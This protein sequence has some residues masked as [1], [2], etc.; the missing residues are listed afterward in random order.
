MAPRSVHWPALRDEYVTGDDH[1]TH[2]T[3]ATKHGVSRET[4]ARH[5]GKEAWSDQRAQYRHQVSLKTQDRASTREA[6]IRARQVQVARTVTGIAL[7]QLKKLNT[8]V[9]VT[10]DG[11]VKLLPSPL[12]KEMTVG[13]VR[14]WIESGMRLEREALGVSEE[15]EL[16]LRGELEAALQRLREALPPDVYEQVLSV[17]ASAKP[18][19]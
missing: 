2:Q 15:V 1:V 13:Q 3:L 7:E 18:G 4:V 6:E 19:S 5:A 17:I 16:R 9:E 8:P 10:R 11:V 12:E 14:L